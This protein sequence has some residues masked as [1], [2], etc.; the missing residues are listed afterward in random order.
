MLLQWSQDLAIGH[1]I[2][3]YDHQMLV[4]IANE[5]HHAVKFDQGDDEVERALGRWV[6]YLKTHFRREEALFMGT[7][8]PHKDKH[9][10][11]HRDIESLVGDF[12]TGF[13]KNPGAVDIEK[14]LDF[15]KTW[16]IKHIGKMDKSY[17]PYVK[18]ME[19]QHGQYN[20][21]GFA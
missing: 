9:L 3:D 12:H 1:P 14:L 10:Q 18:A 16:L 11:N 7:D 17:A 21:T 15:L 4:N 6:Q 20:R 2:I 13:Q 8:Y 19:K 5:L